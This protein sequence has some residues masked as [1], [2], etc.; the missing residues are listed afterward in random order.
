MDPLARFAELLERAKQTPGIAEATGMTLSTVGA[1]G[2]PSARIVLLKGMD[3][4][5]FVF[6]TNYNSCKGR[7]ILARPSVALT[8]WWPQLESQV[9]IEGDAAPV[10]ISEADAYFATRPRGSQLGAWA[11]DQSAEL[12]SRAALEEKLAEV[13]RRF[14]GGPVP[15]PPHWSG[16]RVTPLAIEFWKN[17][18]NRLHE[19]DLYRRENPTAPWTLRLLNP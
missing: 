3:R 5:G 13:T 6:Y 4:Q 18:P 2:R 1:D 7:E 11:S 14:E 12:P 19:R 16:F 9:R 10:P 17:R 8:F 15:R